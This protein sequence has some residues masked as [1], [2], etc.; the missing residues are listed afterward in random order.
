MTNEAREDMMT[1]FQKIELLVA[2]LVAAED[3]LRNSRPTH[4]YYPEPGVRHDAAH[5]M[6]MSALEPYIRRPA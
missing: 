6:V 3:A 2:A 4:D 5:R 1:E